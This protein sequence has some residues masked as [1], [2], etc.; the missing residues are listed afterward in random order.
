MASRWPTFLPKICFSNRLIN[1]SFVVWYPSSKKEQ[2]LEKEK[3]NPP[4]F[5]SQST[6]AEKA[7]ETKTSAHEE[8]KND[9]TGTFKRY[10]RLADQLLSTD[11]KGNDPGSSAA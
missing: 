1:T 6:P 7:V 10:L 9:D 4:G 3:E 11:K 5:L 2:K 8:V